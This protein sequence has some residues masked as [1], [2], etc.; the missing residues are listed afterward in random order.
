MSSPVVPWLQKYRF[1]LDRNYFCMITVKCHCSVPQPKIVMHFK[2]CTVCR[3]GQTPYGINIRD[4]PGI[5]IFCG[6]GGRK[7]EHPVIRAYIQTTSS[8][9][10]VGF[11]LWEITAHWL[12]SMDDGMRDGGRNAWRPEH[13]FL[14]AIIRG[15]E[16][17]KTFSQS[18]KNKK[19][20]PIVVQNI[21]FKIKLRKPYGTIVAKSFL[22]GYQGT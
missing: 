7:R 13:S 9:S 20:D 21:R 14:F 1:V 3:D 10:F 4:L 8:D 11:V 5:R 17:N 15:T 19:T 2:V 6:S 12:I 18:H 22:L 16:K